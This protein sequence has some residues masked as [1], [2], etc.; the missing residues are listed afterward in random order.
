[1]RI[2]IICMPCGHEEPVPSFDTFQ[3]EI[4]DA[5][6][7]VLRCPRGHETNTCLQEQKFEVLFDLGAHAI[8]DGYYREAVSSFAASLERFYEFYLSVL[9]VKAGIPEQQFTDVWKRVANQSERQLGAFT[10]VYLIEEQQIPP[11]LPEKAIAF[12]NNVIHKG[13]VPTRDE[14]ISFGC[15][16]MQLVAPTLAELKAKHPEHVSTV[17]G[18]HVQRTRNMVQ[19]NP[20]IQFLSIATIISIVRAN[21]EPQPS[22]EQA[23]ERITNQKRRGRHYF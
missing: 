16:V 17:V 1:M 4:Q 12:R 13:R 8:V 9:A 7:Y 11:I 15:E 5:G 21:S 14:A 22:L 19:G 3:V 23:I 2:P 6:L 20:K 18:R 10:F